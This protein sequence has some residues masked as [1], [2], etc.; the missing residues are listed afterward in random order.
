MKFS[1]EEVRFLLATHRLEF[2]AGEPR[3]LREMHDLRA[4]GCPTPLFNSVL[5]DRAR[6]LGRKFTEFRFAHSASV[7]AVQPSL[8]DRITATK[9]F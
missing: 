2:A 8:E 6:R 3:P 7:G 9:L 1:E 5:E 4:L